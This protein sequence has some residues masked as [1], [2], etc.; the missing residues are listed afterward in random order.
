M[1]SA[2]SASGHPGFAIDEQVDIDIRSPPHMAGE[3]RA[4]ESRAKEPQDAH[5]A[6]RLDSHLAQGVESS[7]AFMQPGERLNLIANLAIAGQVGRLDPSLTEPFAGL[8][9]GPIVF[10]FLAAVHESGRLERD[11]PS[12]FGIGHDSRRRNQAHRSGAGLCQDIISGAPPYP[13]SDPEKEFSSRG[14]D[15]S[16]TAL[17]R[18][19][20]P[21]QAGGLPV[22]RISGP[23]P[24]IRILRPAAIVD[25]ISASPRR[26][27]A[28]FSGEFLARW[29]WERV[30]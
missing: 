7:R 12:Q 8:E 26:S 27:A 24:R 21:G 13:E 11:L 28:H 30:R 1:P 18:A 15:E 25:K 23:S 6:Q 3:R 20:A 16:P 14:G 10:R 2:S 4:D 19:H 29:R 17:E 22:T 9:L 5:H